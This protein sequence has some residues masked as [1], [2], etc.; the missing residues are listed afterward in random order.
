MVENGLGCRDTAT[1]EEVVTIGF[2]PDAQFSAPFQEECVGVPVPFIDESSSYADTWHWQF[3]DGEES[4]EP[5]PTHIFQ[6]TGFYDISLMVGHNG[7]TNE[8]VLNDYIH[9][10][11]PL[12]KFE[13]LQDCETLYSV[14]MEDRSVGAMNV[15][16]D[17]GLTNN[18][19]DNSTDWNPTFTYPGPGEYVITQT[20]FNNTTNCSHTTE[21]TVRITD[22]RANY[23]VSNTQGCAPLSVSI[24]DLS[25]YAASWTWSATGGVFSNDQS[26]EPTV[27]FDQPGAYTD[28]T[29]VITDE[30]GC[31]DTLVFPDTI[32]ANAIEMDLSASPAVG[33]RP[34]SVQFTDQSVNLFA[35][36]EV[37]DWSFG[38]GQG[39]SLDRNPAHTYYESG[40]Y[41]ITLL[42]RDSWGCVGE[43]TLPNEVEVTRP[44][45]SF[46][47]Q[48][49]LACTQYCVSFVNESIG[50]DISFL[51]AFGDGESSTDENP[52]HCYQSEGVYSVCLTVTDG[53]GCDST[54]CRQDY[55]IIADPVAAFT[56]DST[57][58]SCPP[59]PVNF[60]NQSQ[61]AT[62]FVWDFGNNSGANTQENPA[63]IY[64]IPGSYAVTLIAS[65]TPNCRDTAVLDDFIVLDGPV[66]SFSY[67]ADSTCTPVEVTFVAESFTDYM[68]I[69]DF[70]DGTIDTVNQVDRDTAIHLYTSA[71]FYRPALSLIDNNSCKRTLFSP[72]SIEVSTLTLD[73]VAS[74]TLFCDQ[75]DPITFINLSSSS[76]DDNQYSW[77]FEG[78]NPS[79]SDALEPTV[80]YDQPGIYDVILIGESGFCR[81]TIVKEDYIQL[82]PSPIADF[83]VSATIG[84]D[85]FEVQFTNMST[86]SAGDIATYLWDFGD[87]TTSTEI[88]P[89]HTFTTEAV[90]TLTVTSEIGCVGMVSQAIELYPLPEIDMGSSFDACIGEVI[91]LSASILGDTTGLEYQWL[92]LGSVDCG[93]CLETT[94]LVN[95]TTTFE[96]IVRT[97]DGCITSESLTINVGPQEV[98][99]IT[100][101]SDTIICPEGPY[102]IFVG[103]GGNVFEYDWDPSRPGLTCYANC[104]NPIA[105]PTVPTTYVVTVTNAVGCT[106]VDSIFVDVY[107]EAYGFAGDDRAICKGDS[108]LLE[109]TG[110][111]EVTWLV[112]DQLS[113]SYCPDPIAVPEGTTDYIVR[114][115]DAN[116]CILFDTVQ[117]RVVETD[118]FTAGADRQICIGESL[119]LDAEAQGE[120]QWTP[121]DLFDQSTTT[122]PIFTGVVTSEVVMTVTDDACTYSDTVRIEVI[123]K[124]DIEVEDQVVCLGDSVQL[125]VEGAADIINW[126]VNGSL[127]N[128]TSATPW[129]TPTTDQAYTVVAQL[130]SCIPDTVT[131]L[132]EVIDKPILSFNRVPGI[133]PGQPVGI[134]VKVE[135]EGNYTYNWTPPDLL[136]CTDCPSPIAN[137]DEQTTLMVE[138][139]DE[140][141]GCMVMDSIVLPLL[142]SCPEELVDIPNVFSPNGDGVNDELKAFFARGLEG[143]NRFQVLDRWGTPMFETTDPTQGWDGTFNGV[144]APEGVYIY[145]LEVPCPLDG[146]PFLK[147]GDVSL[148]R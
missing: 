144:P 66:G 39:N 127:S 132:V 134:R 52:T 65:S 98:P 108:I 121:A 91:S 15:I 30:K 136:N 58:A 96:L 118:L 46:T 11:E 75:Y 106:S 147:T 33:C 138:V 131:A 5:N 101:P 102:Q 9:I 49:T 13:I 79:S 124:T 146:Q 31:Q 113:C 142:S 128:W 120:I 92:P 67:T 78:A 141:T 16:W 105:Q 129:A 111:Q 43:L 116:D 97:L 110:V 85:P 62:D 135:P 143:L 36:N 93:S 27:T 55:I 44:R 57:F 95:D 72:D 130:R 122:T 148:V 22:P 61:N 56:S 84:C 145:F 53:N 68:Y 64:T 70:G 42:I 100:L 51:W 38:V 26:P 19:S 32:Y 117:V 3:G 125:L 7:C 123:D 10:L 20:V 35:T 29:L 87:G 109:T 80:I 69:W 40:E 2:F 59:L 83:N 126:E 48:D 140:E 60:Y 28:L 74:D 90:V 137:A 50:K 17:F 34:L 25:E 24:Q 112:N 41:D 88:D 114:G 4:F 18:S 139:M 94:A 45:A 119:Q 47:T 107:D 12:S 103:G 23:T 115:T 37:W 86:L 54:M 6:D 77:Q 1:F 63:H 71:G 82:G 21:Q 8:L 89:I 73:F 76:L 99:Q 14:T 81:D 133:F 104:F